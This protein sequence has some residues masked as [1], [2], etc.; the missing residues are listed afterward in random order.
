VTIVDVRP[1]RERSIPPADGRRPA[2]ADRARRRR[3]RRLLGWSAL[4]ALLVLAIAAALLGRAWATERGIDA[5]DRSVFA[6][7]RAAD[8]VEWFDRS[9]WINLYDREVPS[10]NRGIAWFRAGE[11][12]RARSDFERALG[13]AGDASRCRV[14]VNLAL[15]VE[16]QGDAAAEIDPID[17]Q[18]L[19]G[20]SKG[21]VQGHGSCLA[22]TTPAGDGE[23][24]RLQRLLDRLED[25]LLETTGREV[26]ASNAD[27]GSGREPDDDFDQLERRLDQNAETRSEGRELEEDVVLDPSVSAGPQW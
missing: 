6:R 9:G 22:R 11:L 5:V 16:A 8:A 25:K 23:G 12:A 19:Y 24:D 15:T 27:P 3:R 4:P 18:A 26:S 20:E 2:P 13:L 21:I 1:P 17:S 7:A 14:V 10:F